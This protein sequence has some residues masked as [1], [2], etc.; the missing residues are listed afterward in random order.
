M[1]TAF[2]IGALIRLVGIAGINMVG[3]NLGALW[4]I[5]GVPAVVSALGLLMLRFNIAAPAISM[6]RLR[7][8][9]PLSLIRRRPTALVH[10]S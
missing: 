2:T 7:L 1:F 5:Y 3:K 9:W 8:P 4:L 6:P 10:S